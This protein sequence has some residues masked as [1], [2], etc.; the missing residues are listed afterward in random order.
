MR[1]HV[2]ACDYD[3]TLATLGQVDEHT[4]KTLERV[5]RSGR[6]LLLVT[7]RE[8]DD[9]LTVFPHTDLF[10]LVVAENGGLLYDPGQRTREPLADAP[11]A[12]LVERLRAQGATPLGVGAVVVATREP[13][14]AQVHEAIRELGLE[15]QVIRNKGAV[16]VLPPGVNKASG[17]AAALVRL[18]MSR[19]NVVA[20]GDA[21]NDH[22]FL[23]A[24]ECGA[25]V[26]NAVPALRRQCDL[27]L[28]HDA[29]KGVEQLASLLLSGELDEVEV[30]RHDVLVG[31]E[32]EQ[33]DEEVRLSPY[34]TGLVVAGPSGSGKSTATTA[35][36]ERLVEDDYQCVV[37]DPEG[38]YA[39]FPDVAVLGEPDRPPSVEEVLRLLESP[40]R[41]AV[42]NM[43]GLP[44]RDRPAFFTELLPRLTALRARLGHPHWVVVDEAHHLM[45]AELQEVPIKDVG[46]VGSML[47]ITVHPEALSPAALTLV[48][49]VIAVGPEPGATL[50]AFAGAL[51][52]SAP[53]IEGDG[54]GI[55]LWRTAADTAQRVRIA[56]ARQQR[57]R[58]R[59]KYAAGTMSK[60]KSFYFTGPEERLRLRARNLHT[61]VELAEGV[62]DGT[63][64]H[65]LRQGDYSSWI[66]DK[67]GDDELAD[68]VAAVERDEPDDSLRQVADLIEQRYTLPAEPTTYDPDHD[69]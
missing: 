59:R 21:E 31:H 18:Q 47:M 41:S 1:Y 16:M 32:N 33:G 5:S 9:L 53:D 44:L 4:V 28:D 42:V 10:D 7:G 67:L 12:E 35:L 58:H 65:H 46:E 55:V 48:D 64:T 3:D 38:D 69:D 2:L 19:H 66:R 68:E 17:L 56:P 23:T 60:D 52:R 57:T 25:A 50:S 30:A 54:D 20:V 37:I 43:I 14:D 62:D 6:K 49:S 29:G 24:A 45:P 63:W 13:Y 51:G 11:P 40:E 8:L 61:F 39:E 22:A 27:P 26:A 36:I 34:R 15:L